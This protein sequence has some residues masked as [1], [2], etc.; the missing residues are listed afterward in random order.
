MNLTGPAKHLNSQPLRHNHLCKTQLSKMATTKCWPNEDQ[1][2][3]N[4]TNRAAI[5]SAKS[6]HVQS[7]TGCG[8][9]VWKNRDVQYICRDR[10]YQAVLSLFRPRKVIK[11][12]EICCHGSVKSANCTSEKSL[13][14]GKI[15]PVYF[16]LHFCL[17]LKLPMKSSSMTVK[18]TMIC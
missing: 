10:K 11:R 1:A 9:T 17:M 16:R 12:A 8:Q 7:Q 18:G 6:L 14:E 15:C 2:G 5:L 3:N 13:N 4:W